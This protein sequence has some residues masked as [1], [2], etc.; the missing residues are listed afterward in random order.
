VV[1]EE[2]LVPPPSMKKKASSFVSFLL[3]RKTRSTSFANETIRWQ[4]ME[5]DIPILHTLSSL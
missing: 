4:A 2:Q 5:Q 3:G 1:E